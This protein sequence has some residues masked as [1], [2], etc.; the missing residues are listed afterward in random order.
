[1]ISIVQNFICT[2]PERITV[3]DESVRTLAEAFPNSIFYV[4]YNSIINLDSV[5]NI[6][7]KYIDPK[8]LNFYNDLNPS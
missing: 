1:M 6:Y 3:L 5:H 2:K 7:T 4:N 8:Y